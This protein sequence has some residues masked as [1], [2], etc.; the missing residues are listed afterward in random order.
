MNNYDIPFK[1][2][3]KLSLPKLI[4]TIFMS[5]FC[6][7]AIAFAF[8]FMIEEDPVVGVSVIIV[9]FLFG[10]FLLYSLLL[11]C[12]QK[13]MRIELTE[14]YLKSV[15]F[16]GEKIIYWHEIDDISLSEVPCK[17]ENKFVLSILLKKDR[18]KKTKNTFFNN[19][20]LLL[21]DT[22]SSFKIT[23]EYYKNINID[24]LLKTMT[25]LMNS[26]KTEFD[27]QTF[28][29]SNEEKQKDS[30][31][32]GVLASTLLSI[33]CGIVYGISNYL[34]ESNLAFIPLVSSIM[35]PS[36]F[37]TFYCK[38]NT[39][40]WLRL[41]LGL[42]CVTTVIIGLILTLLISSGLTLTFDLA[43]RYLNLHLLNK[44]TNYISYIITAVIC[45]PIGV[46]LK[47]P[48]NS[49]FTKNY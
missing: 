19:I 40:L 22:P 46:F 4:L 17:F 33:F 10:S 24:S 2:T 48:T 21:G 11:I 42:L 18:V 6:L 49:L 35:I 3:A 8:I 27:V 7:V 13:K 41:I 23:L 1:I 43:L 39:K 30:A 12:I 31:L 16:T 38:D 29:S 9:M 34:F 32:K 5:I 14:N 44:T 47:Y 28:I 25:H 20:N 26:N 36:L 45:F 37:Y 15:S